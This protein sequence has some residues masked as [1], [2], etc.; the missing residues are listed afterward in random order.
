MITIGYKIERQYPGYRWMIK[1]NGEIVKQDWS[2]TFIG[3][4]FKAHR[5]AKATYFDM[6]GG[7]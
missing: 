4:W 7:K 1:V 3:A 2:Q 5:S 6:F